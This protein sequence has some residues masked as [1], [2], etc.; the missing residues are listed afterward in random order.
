MLIDCSGHV[1]GGGGGGGGVLQALTAAQALV[2]VSAQD[3][4]VRCSVFLRCPSRRDQL[5]SHL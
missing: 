1:Y 4:A 3:D 2:Q 5:Y